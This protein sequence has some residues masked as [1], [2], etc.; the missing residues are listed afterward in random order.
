MATKVNGIFPT[1]CAAFFLFITV[2]TIACF[3]WENAE[4]EFERE[5]WGQKTDNVWYHEKKFGMAIWLVRHYGFVGKT[6]EDIC[7]D[8]FDN[9]AEKFNRAMKNN[10]IGF[11]LR[12]KSQKFLFYKYHDETAL[13]SDACMKI[14]FEDDIVS[15]AEIEELMNGKWL[16]SHR[17]PD[18]KTK[19]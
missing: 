7:R 17:D 12:N 16:V 5:I 18:P 10:V 6:R 8:F 1:V 9:D 3:R 11:E 19:A 15:K 14:Y 4:V 2:S 13:H